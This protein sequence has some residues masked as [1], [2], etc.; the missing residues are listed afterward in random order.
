MLLISP[1]IQHNHNLAI[2]PNNYVEVVVPEG[3]V[4]SWESGDQRPFGF[5]FKNVDAVSWDQFYAPGT[6][7]G[8]PPN[9]FGDLPYGIV[10]PSASAPI[11]VDS[12]ESSIVNGVTVVRETKIEGFA[13]YWQVDATP[14]AARNDVRL[15]ASQLRGDFNFNIAPRTTI[16]FAE[17]RP[18]RSLKR[19]P[20]TLHQHFWTWGGAGSDSTRIAFGQS[21]ITLSHVNPELTVDIDGGTSPFDYRTT[22][23]QVTVHNQVVSPYV[24]DEFERRQWCFGQRAGQCDR[25]SGPTGS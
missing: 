10:I 20:R 15:N 12:F 21:D 8:D 5:P 9:P 22:P 1:S 19:S 4:I 17:S 6:G 24:E 3:Q 25:R 14:E 11:E 2:N 16:S 13:R 7:N 23:N 18:S